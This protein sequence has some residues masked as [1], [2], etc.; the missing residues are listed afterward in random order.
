MQSDM[1]ACAFK[2]PRLHAA[3]AAARALAGV[4]KSTAAATAA[5]SEKAPGGRRGGSAAANSPVAPSVAASSSGGSSPRERGAQLLGTI[6]PFVSGSLCVH[7]SQ[8]IDVLCH[9]RSSC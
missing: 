2:H 8:V 6:N 7:A 5:A 1:H 4:A 3:Q 9:V